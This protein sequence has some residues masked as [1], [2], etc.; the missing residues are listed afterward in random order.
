ML[1]FKLIVFL[2]L[3]LLAYGYYR[4]SAKIEKG[5]IATENVKSF[6]RRLES[7]MSSIDKSQEAN[8]K[9]LTDAVNS[10]R[11]IWQVIH[12]VAEKLPDNPNKKANQATLDAVRELV[13]RS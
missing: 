3:A 9:A 13:S 7:L 5:D 2:G 10:L 4:L 6:L 1:A 11:A 8:S 12:A